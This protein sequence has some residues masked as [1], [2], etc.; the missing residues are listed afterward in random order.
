[1]TDPAKLVTPNANPSHFVSILDSLKSA[2]ASRNYLSFV[3]G[4]GTLLAGLG[5]MDQE[6]VQGLVAAVQ[7]IMSG[8]GTMVGGVQKAWLLVGPGLLL[9]IGRYAG[10]ASS[11]FGRVAAVNKDAQKDGIQVVVADN[12]KLAP[13]VVALPGTTATVA[14][15]EQPIAV[16]VP[17]PA[18]AAKLDVPVGFYSAGGQG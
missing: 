10:V 11:I 8:F 1:M 14:P 18:P 13:L 2:A 9:V 5:V 4:A 7:E 12:S 17:E 6:S 16:K 15:P 3:L